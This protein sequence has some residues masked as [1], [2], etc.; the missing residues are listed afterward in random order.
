MTHLFPSISIIANSSLHIAECA[1]S[2]NNWCAASLPTSFDVT[3]H[4][5]SFCLSASTDA[6]ALSFFSISSLSVSDVAVNVLVCLSL[7]FPIRSQQSVARWELSRSPFVLIH[8]L[9]PFPPKHRM[10]QNAQLNYVPLHPKV[11]WIW[12]WFF[13]L[14]S[15][16]FRKYLLVLILENLHKQTILGTHFIAFRRHTY[17]CWH[18]LS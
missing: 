17:N 2:P 12:P 14:L 5:D 11:L 18:A 7:L 16:P 13:L 15:F 6:S 9:F 8:T 4:V 1:L 3:T 10:Y